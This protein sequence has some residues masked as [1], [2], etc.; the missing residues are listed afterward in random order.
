M[1]IMARM[2][3]RRKGKSGSHKPTDRGMEWVKLKPA[4]VEELIVKHASAGMMS[5]QVGLVLRDQ[6][7]IA[8]VRDH[9]KVRIARVMKKHGIATP[10]PEDMFS[11]MKRAVN[12]MNHL[13]KN[14]HDYTSKR[15]LYL[16][17]S[18]IRRLAK[19]YKRKKILPHD[20]K[21]NADKARLMVK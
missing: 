19:Y 1:M 5:A 15:G 10:V 8:S 9:S 16:T 2:Y 12:L 6:H 7:G 14:K 3:S 18:K 17:E 20:W 21:Y 4:E 13:A 11:L